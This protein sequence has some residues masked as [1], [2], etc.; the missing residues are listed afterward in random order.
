MRPARRLEPSQAH[1]ARTGSAVA[2]RN[3]SAASLQRD[4]A[5]SGA[6]GVLLIAGMRY[7]LGLILCPQAQSPWAWPLNAVAVTLRQV[8]TVGVVTSLAFAITD[9]S[10]AVW[11]EINDRLGPRMLVET[12]VHL[13]WS[14]PDGP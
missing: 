1:R 12:A 11:G 9:G 8:L 5:G 13:L 4:A 7:Q 3:V 10:S 6:R 2:L 14:A